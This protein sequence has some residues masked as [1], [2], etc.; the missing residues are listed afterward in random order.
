MATRTQFQKAH[1]VSLRDGGFLTE[2]S[3]DGITAFA[4]GGQANATPL[5]G[6]L[7]RVATVASAGDSVMLPSNGLVTAW[8]DGPRGRDGLAVVVR[9]DGANALAV[10]PE[11]SDTIDGGAAS[12]SVS[13]PAGTIASFYCF[14]AGAWFTSLKAAL[15]AVASLSV[16]ALS[17]SAANALTAHAGGG[18]GSAL[19][20]SS[21]VN[22]VTT[23]ATAADSVKLPPATVG[24]FQ[25]V[26][27]K[28][29]SN[30][31][32]VFG[33]GT[34]TI[35]GVATGT[36]VSLAAGKGALFFCA[37]AGAWDQILTA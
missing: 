37:V 35:N 6:Q 26:F 17:F 16:A 11:G 29:A 4:G 34:D 9:N 14:T 24:G 36:G 28:A 31:M 1:G 20:L 23:V 15:G 27:N 7:N 18:Q 2:Y 5:S 8:S 32:Q 21:I 10:F 33:A 12:A 30:A 13:L 3:V 25:V 22:R 19:A